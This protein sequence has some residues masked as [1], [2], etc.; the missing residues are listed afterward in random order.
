MVVSAS[1]IR[2]GNGTSAGIQARRGARPRPAM[3]TPRERTGRSSAARCLR[4]AAL[5]SQSAP[6]ARRR[7]SAEP[8]LTSC[9]KIKPGLSS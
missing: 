9:S 3:A 6:D 8:K 2:S 7:V 4:P 1:K 5:I